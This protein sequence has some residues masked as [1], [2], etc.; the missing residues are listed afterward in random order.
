MAKTLIIK[1][2]DFS[3]NKIE[4]VTFADVPCT[5]ISL[6]ED[7]ISLTSVGS[8]FTLTATLTPADT[9]DTVVWSTS[10]ADVATVSNGVVTATGCGTATITATCGQFSATCAVGVIHVA[11]LE[12][13]L[14][15]YASK[16]SSKDFL[17]GGA[18]TN[19]A[20]AGSATGNKII[21]FNNDGMFDSL[22]PVVI[23]TGATKIEILCQ[24]FKPYGFWVSSTQ[25]SSI[26]SVSYAYAQD[27]NFKY[28]ANINNS[29][30]VTIPERSTGT[31]EGADAAAFVFRCN[32][33]ISQEAVN[34][35]TVTFSKASS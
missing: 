1:S 9:S 2:A 8:T 19:Y 7:S 35:I 10:D 6:D 20:L 4:K 5:G 13:V 23:P 3:T 31:Y 25:G 11:S 29:R 26:P 33:T 14:D 32:S 12:Y 22:H 24:G 34:A 16:D 17:S 15:G 28:D 21:A 27:D 18:L 30:T